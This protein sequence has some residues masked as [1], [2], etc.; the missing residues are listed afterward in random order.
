MAKIPAADTADTTAAAAFEK[1]LVPTIFGPWSQALVDFA[2]ASPGERL[3]DVGCGT[4]AAARYAADLLE[5]DGAV[6]AIDLNA[7]MIA[8]AQTLDSAGAVDW[9]EGDVTSL[10]FDDHSFDIIVGNQVLQFLTDRAGGLAEIRRVLADGGRA[11][12]AVWCRIELCPAHFA[13]ANALA[14]HDV[15]PEGILHPYSLGDPV[16]LGDIIAD[17]GFRDISVVRR[18]ME[19]RFASAKAFIDALV[20]GG[21]SSRRALAQLEADGLG[22]VIADVADELVEFVDD[23]GL[24]VLTSANLAMARR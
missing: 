6:A 22:Q 2:R 24:R 19:A 12:F 14:R 13:V 11:A 17:A 3:L 18:P 21:P 5:S 7:G 16:A 9:H 10:P 20:G 15:D 8:H 4:G 23:D 1:Y